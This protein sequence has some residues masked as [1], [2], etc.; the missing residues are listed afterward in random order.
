MTN[1]IGKASEPPGNSSPVGGGLIT[2]TAGEF[3]YFTATCCCIVLCKGSKWIL[4]GLLTE[5]I[6]VFSG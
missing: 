3:K 1:L 6:R 2:I 5:Y 4:Y